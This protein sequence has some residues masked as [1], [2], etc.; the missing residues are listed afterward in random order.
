MLVVVDTNIL[1]SALIN[2]GGVPARVVEEIRAQTLRPLVCREILDEYREVLTRA[3]FRFS[4][5]LVESLLDDLAALA[6]HLQPVPVNI[7]QLPAPNDAP[8]IALA[9]AAACP[10]VTGN[11]R[12]FPPECGVEV[13]TPGQCL[14]RLFTE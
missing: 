6:L 14:T 8:F 10:I 4:S 11:G 7:E 1:V 2:P 3:R 9:L 5:S 12:H 13:L